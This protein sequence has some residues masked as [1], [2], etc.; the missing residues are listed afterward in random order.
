M[1]KR[2]VGRVLAELKSIHSD[3]IF[4]ADTIKTCIALLEADM[5]RRKGKGYLPPHQWHSDTSRAAAEAI[6][7]KFG[8]ITRNV[9]AHLCTYPDGLTDEEG[10]H[11]IGMEGN[12]Y[13]PCRVTLMDKGFVVDSGH[14]R[15]THQRK[16]AVVW[17]VTPE[18]F[19]ALEEI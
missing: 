4:V 16:D 12:S 8:T 17:S 19:L 9:L 5:G 14:R 2:I 1:S 15:K 6:A 11:T 18:G 13:R 10:Q 7:P 3:D